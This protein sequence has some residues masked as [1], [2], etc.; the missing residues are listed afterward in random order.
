MECLKPLRGGRF[1]RSGSA[2]LIV[3]RRRIL[4]TFRALSP[5]G[6]FNERSVS[7]ARCDLLELDV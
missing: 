5:E 2:G 3:A 4:A 7:L 6:A 1:G